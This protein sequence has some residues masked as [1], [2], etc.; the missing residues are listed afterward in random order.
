M[1]TAPSLL[2]VA[3]ACT[4]Q[5]PTGDL[6]CRVLSI[7]LLP[8]SLQAGAPT[9]FPC[10]PLSPHASNYLACVVRCPWP[11]TGPFWPQPRSPSVRLF[12]FPDL[13]CLSQGGDVYWCYTGNDVALCK[14]GP[15]KFKWGRGVGGGKDSTKQTLALPL[16]RRTESCPREPAGQGHHRQ[17]AP[18][19]DLVFQ[20]SRGTASIL[21]S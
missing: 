17:C 14:C 21:Q 7:S 2:L 5:S 18:V 16:P 20:G 13:N 11:H 4:R 12:N 19:R 6:T 10:R 1:K 3:P 8:A 9:Y 15:K